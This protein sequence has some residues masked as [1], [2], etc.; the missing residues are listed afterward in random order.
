M[1]ENRKMSRIK[2]KISLTFIREHV[3]L[4]TDRLSVAKSGFEP[5]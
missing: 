1:A 3:I 5:G 4:L 2:E